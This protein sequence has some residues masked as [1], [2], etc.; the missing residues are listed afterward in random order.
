MKLLLIYYPMP[1]SP[2]LGG[3]SNRSPFLSQN[4]R[5]KSSLSATTSSRG[6]G[7]SFSNFSRPR[8][9]SSV[10]SKEVNRRR[11]VKLSNAS[12][13][14]TASESLTSENLDSLSSSRIKKNVFTASSSRVVT[15]FRINTI[16]EYRGHMPRCGHTA[17]AYKRDFFIFGG[18]ND[19][20]Q[21]PNHVY[22]H[23]KRS[24]QWEEVRGAGV[25]PT[26]R[27]N[28]S[29]ILHKTKMIV[30][31]GHCYLDVYD[32]LYS[33]DFE[34]KKWDKIGYEKRQGPG[35]VFLHTAVYIPVTQS[36]AIIGGFHQREHNMY[37]GHIFDIKNRVWSGIPGPHALNLQHLQLVTATFD[38]KSVSI[39]VLGFTESNDALRSSM[40]APYVYLM[41]IHSFVW[42]KVETSSSP[43]SPI[44]FRLDVIWEK[45]MREFIMMGGGFHDIVTQ[46]WFFPIA[47]DS[48]VETKPYRAEVSVLSSSS[49]VGAKSAKPKY[50]LFKLQLD[51][52]KW[53]LIPMS[54][55]K[56]M[57]AELAQKNRDSMLQ[58]NMNQ[59]FSIVQSSSAVPLSGKG[60]LHALQSS[61]PEES[62]EPINA[63][64]DMTPQKKAMLFSVEGDPQFQR[65]Y[66]FAA[67]RETGSGKATRSQKTKAMQY[68]VMHGGLAPGLDYTLLMLV[69]QISRTDAFA[70]TRID[71][72]EQE[73]SAGQSRT[74]RWLDEFDDGHFSASTSRSRFPMSTV[75]S[76][77][78]GGIEDSSRALLPLEKETS[79]FSAQQRC[80]LPVLPCTQNNNN[81]ERFAVLFHPNNSFQKDDLLRYPTIPVVILE[82]E[83][84]IQ[85]WSERYY[86]D[87]RKWLSE[88]LQ[89]ALQEERSLRRL[90]KN[91]QKSN[92]VLGSEFSEDDDELSLGD[93]SSNS[94]KSKYDKWT[95]AST[96]SDGKEA[97]TVKSAPVP[98]DEDEEKQ[99]DFFIRTGLHLFGMA[100]FENEGPA[101]KKEDSLSHISV[102]SKNLELE[103]AGYSN[104]PP[105][106][107]RLNMR[108]K[109]HEERQRIAENVFYSEN[110]AMIGDLGSA[111]ALVLMRNATDII[112]DETKEDRSRRA[113]IR[114]RYLRALV[115]TGEAA[116]II[117]RANQ[118]ESKKK[119]LGVTSSQGLLLA[120]ELHLIGPVRSAKVS[121]RPIP[122]TTAQRSLPPL[123]PSADYTVSGM[124][125]YRNLLRRD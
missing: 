59:K 25:V 122:Y 98:S 1:T 106:L 80:L 79:T 12:G 19:K 34:A 105:G 72:E 41:N 87:T 33:F 116:F 86:S 84:D 73:S 46:S 92:L 44:P 13:S 11:K 2:A 76:S 69:P 22:R 9:P 48:V 23:E 91:Q 28:H 68:L 75:S 21:Y 112:P 64:E 90:Q 50:G 67:V 52:M 103:K 27:A 18:V 55:P 119:G 121:S 58:R 47:I 26:G 111:M 70:A 118:E 24:L 36:M 6:S 17:V 7:G 10:K 104:C 85:Q 94:Q 43:E 117:Y 78:V 63:D 56:K 95:T 5:R 32:D 35:P 109:R 89:K 3:N 101:A 96:L 113:R 57:I 15:G 14:T 62:M 8:L 20:N 61:V 54:L 30:Y 65:K 88:R 115:R 53:S 71:S 82:A 74:S 83:N 102:N 60:T 29:A 42:T 37:V 66:V 39:V 16:P 49:A 108:V 120:P 51:D 100:D 31:G 4:A 124:V 97:F 77:I 125:V 93:E 123:T 114:W 99:A 107:E 81:M 38:A 110:G 40:Q 45:F